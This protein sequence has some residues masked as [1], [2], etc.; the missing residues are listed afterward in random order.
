MLDLERSLGTM[1]PQE[2]A[3]FP[4]ALTGALRGV[5]IRRRLAAAAAILPLLGLVAVFIALRAP[6][7]QPRPAP[8]LAS[9]IQPASPVALVSLA[10]SNRDWDP[11]RLQLPRAGATRSPALR[12]SDSWPAGH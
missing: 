11:D 2:P 4:A 10:R 3:E 6:A 9:A 1:R 5:R 7:P 8:E 12:A